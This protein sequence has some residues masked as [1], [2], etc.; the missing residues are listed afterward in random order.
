MW[1][2]FSREQAD[3]RYQ[4]QRQEYLNMK[5]SNILRFVQIKRAKK[6]LMADALSIFEGK[7]GLFEAE[8]YSYMGTTGWTNSA[9][10][11]SSIG[12]H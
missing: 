1:C 4:L 8:P 3:A 10:T 7:M 9:R 5:S 11:K 6:Q 12:I 2:V